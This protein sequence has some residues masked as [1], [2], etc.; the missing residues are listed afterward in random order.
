MKESYGMSSLQKSDS[1]IRRLVYASL[2]GLLIILQRSQIWKS[3]PVALLPLL[4]GTVLISVAIDVRR[5]KG[6]KP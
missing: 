4:I 3:V 2:P 5:H 6:I 1:V